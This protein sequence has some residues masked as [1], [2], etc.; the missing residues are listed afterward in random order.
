[1]SSEWKEHLLPVL[2]TFTDNT[3][4]TFIEHKKNSLVW[5]YRKADPE[6]GIARSVELKTVLSSLLPNDLTLLDGNKVLE[7]VPANI[8]KGVVALDIYNSKDYDFVLVAG[9][10]VTDENMFMNLPSEVFKIKVGKKKTAADYFIRNHTNFI[11]LLS[12]LS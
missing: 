9:D 7:L 1:M 10:D 4:G 11:S 3:P 2:D 5:H 8:N 6:L 12:K